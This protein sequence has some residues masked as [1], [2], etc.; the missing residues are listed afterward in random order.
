MYSTKCSQNNINL[1]KKRSIVRMQI[2][3]TLP[4]VTSRFK[5]NEGFAGCGNFVPGSSGVFLASY[6]TFVAFESWF[7]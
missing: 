4:I 5:T 1:E 3:L 2:E 6:L 7:S